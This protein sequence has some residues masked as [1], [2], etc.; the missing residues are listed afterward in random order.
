MRLPLT[1]ICGML[2]T[3]AF[4]APTVLTDIA[5]VHGIVAAVMGDVAAPKLLLPAGTDPHSYAMRPSDAQ[6]LSDSDVVIWVGEGLTPWL[7]DPI[8]TLATGSVLL[9]LLETEGWT[10]RAIAKD[11]HDDHDDHADHDGHDDH[12]DHDDHADHDGHD[13]HADH[14]DHKDHDDHAG[15]DHGDFDPHAWLD[16]KIA[17]IWAGSVAQ[18]LSDV[19]PDNAAAYSANADAFA[20]QM[21]SLSA[22]ITAQ[23]APF[24]GKPVIWPHDAYGYFGDA[25]GITSAGTVTD[26]NGS[27]PGPAHISELR[28]MIAN[29]DIACVMSDAEL[30]PKWTDLITQGTDTASVNIDPMGVA[31]PQGR[32]HYAATITTLANAITDCMTK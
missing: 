15:H 12:K 16:P 6:T 2:A 20:T 28:D 22:T 8:E 7:H 1:A 4:A 27:A 26:I 25:F 29:G 32:D 19:D 17:A 21:A 11:D 18:V 23:L 30:N 31:A 9:T 5:P 24:A 14:D 10:K 13:D 3:P